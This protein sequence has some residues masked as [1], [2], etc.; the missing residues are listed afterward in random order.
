MTYILIHLKLGGIIVKIHTYKLCK[1]LQCNIFEFLAF[2]YVEIPQLS[3]C[4]EGQLLP[5]HMVCMGKLQTSRCHI[6]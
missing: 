3:V 2:A 4:P 1:K 6:L 5:P